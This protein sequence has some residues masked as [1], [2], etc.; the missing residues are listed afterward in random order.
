M[1][2]S[3]GSFSRICQRSH[4]DLTWRSVFLLGSKGSQFIRLFWNLMPWEFCG[5]D[6]H[7]AFEML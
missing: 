5:E 6:C 3:C 2:Y 1:L 4:T 7:W